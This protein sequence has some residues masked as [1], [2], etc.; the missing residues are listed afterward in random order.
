MEAHRLIWDWVDETVTTAVAPTTTT[1]SSHPTST[2]SNIV[3]FGQTRQKSSGRET[4]ETNYDL[5]IL[6][7]V[8]TAH[9]LKEYLV[10]F[11]RTRKASKRNVVKDVR[12]IALDGVCC[13]GM[14]E[15]RGTVQAIRPN[16]VAIRTLS[17]QIVVA[18]SRQVH[19]QQLRRLVGQEVFF[20]LENGE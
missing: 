14:L 4:T 2:S 17:G 16:G 15:R 3:D 19:L 7:L 10:T 8:A 1:A 18:R 6:A 12:R 9:Q 5:H 11:S 13:Q 20:D